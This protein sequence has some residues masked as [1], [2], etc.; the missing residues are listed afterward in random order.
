MDAQAMFE[1]EAER[2]QDA[3]MRALA[4]KTLARIKANI[5]L[6]KP[7]AKRYEKGESSASASASK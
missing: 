3:D 6:I 1:A 4:T 2:G 7:I 5:K